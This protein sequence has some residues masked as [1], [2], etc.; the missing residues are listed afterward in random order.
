MVPDLRKAPAVRD[1]LE[2]PISPLRPAS[3]LRQHPRTTL[4]LDRQ[5]ASL[6][7]ERSALR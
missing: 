3:V 7:V 5:S 1:C 2:L 6:L 4:Y